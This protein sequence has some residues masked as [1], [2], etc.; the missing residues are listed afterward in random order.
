[1]LAGHDHRAGPPLC[2][3]EQEVQRKHRNLAA[4]Y[5]ELVADLTADE[6]DPALA[7][8]VEYLTERARDLTRTRR[9]R[10]KQ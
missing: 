5:T 1:M 9:W 8:R 3:R 10:N 2:P 4:E 7:D 6:P